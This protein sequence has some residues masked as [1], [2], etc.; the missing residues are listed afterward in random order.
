M[1]AGVV[2]EQQCLGL[3]VCNSMYMHGPEHECMHDAKFI[4]LKWLMGTWA[5][6]V[7]A[8]CRQ[9]M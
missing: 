8:A 4:I 7:W 6:M 9:A 2:H 3:S 1:H 5:M